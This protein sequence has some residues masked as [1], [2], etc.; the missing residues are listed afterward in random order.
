MGA[1][2]T[3][4]GLGDPGTP[5]TPA[6]VSRRRATKP[7]G[8][9][10]PWTIQELRL[11]EEWTARA[12]AAQHAHY[13]LTTRLRRANLW[14]G[15]PVVALTAIVS[16]SL[17]AT[18]ASNQGDLPA[19]LQ[20][21][22]ASI[23]LVAGALAAVQT[24][25]RLSQRAEQHM[26]AADWFAAIRRDIEVLLAAPAEEQEDPQEVL[27]GLRRELNTAI[28]KAPEIGE[29]TWHRFADAYGVGEPAELPFPTSAGTT[30]R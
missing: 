15:I 19:G 17:F 26:T 12:S 25:L 22:A 30:P 9:L 21:V 18:L 5:A 23:S 10:R 13:A 6:P 28:Q 8:P 16:T 14:V 3:D 24:F 4:S 20:W 29:R 27:K 11:L 2:G 7:A 1:Q